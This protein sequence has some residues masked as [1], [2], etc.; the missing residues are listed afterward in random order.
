MGDYKNLPCSQCRR[1]TKHKKIKKSD[2]TEIER[3]KILMARIS[4]KELWKC[5]V[6]NTVE[7]FD[8]QD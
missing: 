8:R 3:I 7:M 1:N 2:L 6:C 5:L 4:G